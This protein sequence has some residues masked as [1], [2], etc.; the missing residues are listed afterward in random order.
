MECRDSNGVCW[1][2][3]LAGDPASVISVSRD[4]EPI[5]VTAVEAAAVIERDAR[6]AR[7]WLFLDGARQLVH[8]VLVGEVWWVHVNGSIHRLTRIEPGAD[9][10]G[11]DA[12][13]LTAPM[14]GKVLEV[15]VAV[16]QM[17]MAGDALLVLEA[18][19]MEHRIE[20]PA[21]GLVT[22]VHHAEGAQVDAGAVLIEMAVATSE[23]APE[24]GSEDAAA[25][26]SDDGPDDGPPEDGE[27]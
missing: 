12:G 1:Q 18:M 20:A 21:D 16:G 9:Q 19:K 27:K 5:D 6:S 17:V 4:G 10:G 8:A 25:E 26:G 13:S 23:E 14:P 2:V 15:H 7:I 3:R 22:A 24:E 11:A